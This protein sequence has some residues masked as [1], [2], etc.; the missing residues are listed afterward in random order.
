[1]KID[2]DDLQASL[3][4]SFEKMRYIKPEDI[5]NIDLYMDQVT[6]FLDE[7]LKSSSRVTSDE[8]L[9]TKTMINN[10]AKNEVIPPPNKKKYSKDHILL[11]IFLYYFKSIIQIND[12][13]ELMSPLVDKFFHSSTDFG[14]EDVYNEIFGDMKGKITKIEEDV[15]QKYK[16]SMKS[17]EDAPIGDQDYLRL[18]SFVCSLGGD[19]FVKTLL[20]EKV[21]D[22]IKE[23]KESEK[24]KYVNE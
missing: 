16:E 15:N 22:S 11:L 23:R 14:M 7:G 1:M 24:N 18:F 21:I 12:V 5:P 4:E 2:I 20:I 8:K 13:K 19:V 9:V 3:M 10:Y 17:F 6:T